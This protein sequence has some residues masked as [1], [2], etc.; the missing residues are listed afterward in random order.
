[1]AKS[2]VDFAAAIERKC[3]EFS[4]TIL[5]GHAEDMEQY[6][7][8][9]AQWDDNTHD[10]RN[11]IK[12]DAFYHPGKD[13]GITLA[14]SEW[15]GIFVEKQHGPPNP[16][17]RKRHDKAWWERWASSAEAVSYLETANDS[18]NAILGPT[19]RHFLPQIKADLVKYFGG[20]G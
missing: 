15:Y 8:K 14:F 6:A 20:K 10:L 16:D 12:G 1:M 13:M 7:R 4:E 2:G 3:K 5:A 9:N 19:A 18:K 17:P 11:G